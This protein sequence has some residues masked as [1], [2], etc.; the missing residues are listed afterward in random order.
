TLGRRDLLDGLNRGSE[1]EVIQAGWQ[2]VQRRGFE[3]TTSAGSR[4]AFNLH[5]EN[6]RLRDR[7]G[8]NPL[9][10]NLLLARRLVE[11][12]VGCVMVNGWTGPSPNQVQNNGPPASSWDMH[13]AEMGMGSSF[14]NGSYGLGWC[15]PVL[16]NALSALLTDLDERGLLAST[17]VVAL[18]EF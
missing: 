9:G 3:I 7:Y 2:D 18:G 4:E 16:D 6:T 5:R 15:L 1:G 8:R 13:G 11:S 17:L 10:Q 14:G 12:G